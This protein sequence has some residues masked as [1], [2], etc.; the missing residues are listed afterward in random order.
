MA[1]KPYPPPYVPQPRRRGGSMFG[2]LMLALAIVLYVVN[3]GK[4]QKVRAETQRETTK[5]QKG[6]FDTFEDGR[7]KVSRPKPAVAVPTP[8]LEMGGTAKR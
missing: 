1:A 4:R 7:A 3:D 8:K 6:H 2:M 5:T